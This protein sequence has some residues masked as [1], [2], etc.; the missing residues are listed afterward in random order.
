MGSSVLWRRG[1]MA[2]VYVWFVREKEEGGERTSDGGDVMQ[3]NGLYQFIYIY[4]Y[5]NE[6]LQIVTYYYI[7]YSY[8][9]IKIPYIDWL[10]AC[11]RAIW[12][13]QCPLINIL[14]HEYAPA[15]SMTM[16]DSY[17]TICAS[18][19][20]CQEADHYVKMARG[21]GHIIDM[22]MLRGIWL[23]TDYHMLY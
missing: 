16:L 15:F 18:T 14:L 19:S 22:R 3:C 7:T 21:V 12:Y 8:G 17:I 4:I 6:L 5:M 11:R 1:V 10:A 13:L 2:C 9:T 20:T 23:R